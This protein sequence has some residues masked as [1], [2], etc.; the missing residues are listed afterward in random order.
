MSRRKKRPVSRDIRVP[1]RRLHTASKTVLGI[2][3]SSSTIGWGLVAVK[4]NP[5]L[6]AYGHIKPLPSKNNALVKRLNDVYCKVEGLC[7]KYDP[8]EVAIEDI[9]TYMKGRSSG[10]TMTIL[11]AFNRVAALSAYRTMEKDIIFYSVHT[12]RKLIKNKYLAKKG[13]VG[14]EDMP[15]LIQSHLEKTFTGPLNTKGAIATETLDEADG[16]AVAW[17]RAIDIG[18]CDESV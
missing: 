8:S 16:I 17:A 7:E 18:S 3:C 1:R 14:K 5:T 6:L 12:I 9:F 13:K 11:A 4:A 2:D 15:L 10:Q